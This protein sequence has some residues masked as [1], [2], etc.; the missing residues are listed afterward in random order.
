MSDVINAGCT[1]SVPT[2]PLHSVFKLYSCLSFGPPSG[3]VHICRT[4]RGG[5][6][7]FLQPAVAAAAHLRKALDSMTDHKAELTGNGGKS[8]QGCS[9]EEPT[10]KMHDQA[11]VMAQ[12][13]TVQLGQHEAET[14]LSK[15]QVRLSNDTPHACTGSPLGAV[16][17]TSLGLC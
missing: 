16:T 4:Q 5:S 13:A 9:A 10:Q 11:A 2:T 17:R 7:S 1:I 8:V 14:G 6:E 15:N 3:G 12:A